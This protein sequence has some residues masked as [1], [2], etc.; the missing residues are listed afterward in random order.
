MI[1]YFLELCP[2]L[3]PVKKEG[4]RDFLNLKFPNTL[5]LVIFME[6][7]QS[8]NSSGKIFYPFTGCYYS[9]NKLE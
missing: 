8:N 7:N 9:V 5:K 3:L 2:K 4:V 1:H 6:D